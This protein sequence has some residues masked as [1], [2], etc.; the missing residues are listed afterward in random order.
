[1]S[2]QSIINSAQTIEFARGALAATTM[3]RSGR[4]ITSSRNWVKPWVFTIT[5]KPVWNYADSRGIIEDIITADRITE[6]TISFGDNANMA[7]MMQKQ[8]A[9]VVGATGFVIDNTTDFNSAILVLQLGNANT[10]HTAGTKLFKAGDIIQPAGHRYPYVVT[11]DVLM[12]SG[13]VNGSTKIS[14]ILNRALLAEDGYTFTNKTLVA[15]ADCMWYVKVTKL[16]TLKFFAKDFI[17]FTSDFE[18][19]EVVL[20]A[21]E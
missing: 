16:P 7:W 17:Q 2:I 12:P 6:Q 13:S 9:G 3:S 14:V 10:G 18:I 4:L 15:G 21:T 20:G 1:M 19:T 8:G 11:S 5:P